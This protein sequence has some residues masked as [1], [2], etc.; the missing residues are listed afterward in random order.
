MENN[1]A[2]LTEAVHEK[3][4]SIEQITFFDMKFTLN[5]VGD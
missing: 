1:K 3:T 4:Y 2:H 5:I